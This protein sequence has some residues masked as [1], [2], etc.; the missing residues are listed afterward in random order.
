[1]KYTFNIK[2]FSRHHL[3]IKISDFVDIKSISTESNIKK[4]QVDIFLLEN[5]D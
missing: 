5:P 2:S 1:V 3:K 4:D